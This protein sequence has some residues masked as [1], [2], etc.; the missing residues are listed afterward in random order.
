[1]NPWLMLFLRLFHSTIISGSLGGLLG[2]F[3]K[4]KLDQFSF[5]HQIRFSAFH[6]KQIEVIGETYGRLAEIHANAENLVI[7]S[8]MWHQAIQKALDE[9]T[10]E[11]FRRLDDY[12][13][14]HRIYLEP[15]ICETL[16]S[17]KARIH[18]T[19][20]LYHYGKDVQPRDSQE[21]EN[22]F[23]EAVKVWKEGAEAKPLLQK[24]EQAFRQKVSIEAH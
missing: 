9:E 5:E 8:H 10:G 12:Y 17:L 1:M 24:L 23:K 16:D 4:Y 13:R 11:S 6:Q 14:S 20:Q 2:Y 15:D 21:A 22:F 3:V 18:H 7:S 19:I